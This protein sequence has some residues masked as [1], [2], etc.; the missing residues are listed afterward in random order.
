MLVEL[1]KADTDGTTLQVYLLGQVDF[2]AALRLQR[3]LHFEVTGDRASA[4]LIVCEHPP[5]ISVGRQGSRSHIRLDTDAVDLRGWPIRWV[6]RGGG[7]V[8]HVPGQLA[9]YSIL[10][11]DRL[12]LGI[13]EYISVLGETIR[14]LLDDFTVRSAARGAGVWAGGRCA[15]VIGVSVRDWVTSYGAY[16]NVHPPLDFFRHVCLDGETMT[17]L[18]RERGGPVRPSLVRERLVEH[19]RTRFGFTKAICFT[20]HPALERLGRPTSIAVRAMERV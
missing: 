6:N 16:I 8:L 13:A 15:A 2:A 19:F 18:E 20:E 14:D 11:L 17:S 7:C 12:G 5:T 1:P 3:R 4:A 9:F 10:P